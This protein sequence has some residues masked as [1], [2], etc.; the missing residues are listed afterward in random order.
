M[1]F[2]FQDMLTNW[3]NSSSDGTK[4][5]LNKMAVSR[6]KKFWTY[7]KGKRMY[8]DSNFHTLPLMVQIMIFQQCPGMS[9]YHIDNKPI[10][11]RPVGGVCWDFFVNIITGS[12]LPHVA[13]IQYPQKPAIYTLRMVNLL[14]YIQW[15]LFYLSTCVTRK[16]TALI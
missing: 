13:Q 15:V 2:N 14:R 6:R 3:W 1:C 12:V 7:F 16:I 11:W 5:G 4:K 9:W 10:S 8:L